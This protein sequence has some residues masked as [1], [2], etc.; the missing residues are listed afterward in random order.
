MPHTKAP[1]A[2]VEQS[3]LSKVLVLVAGDISP[4][5]MHQFEHACMNY[6]IHKKVIVDDQVSVVNIPIYSPFSPLFRV[7][8]TFLI[9][10]QLPSFRLYYLETTD[11]FPHQIRF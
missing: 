5:T 4:A 3:A 7:S 11:I 9:S 6:F 1:V 10:F 2:S 8:I